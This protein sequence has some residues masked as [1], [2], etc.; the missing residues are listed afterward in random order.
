M[1]QA[2]GAS[3]KKAISI[4]L[5]V[6]K[7]GRSHAPL[8]IFSFVL[9]LFSQIE[10]V[11]WSRTPVYLHVNNVKTTTCASGISLGAGQGA[12]RIMSR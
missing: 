6:E 1:C 4:A 3:S 2:T 11:Y 5:L 7:K 8:I 9:L 12:K 10:I